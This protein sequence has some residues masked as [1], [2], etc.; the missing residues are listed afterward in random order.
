MAAEFKIGSRRMR[1]ISTMKVIWLDNGAVLGV[2][3]VVFWIEVS[4]EFAHYYK[5]LLCLGLG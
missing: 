5:L 3:E 1:E 4:L 2:E